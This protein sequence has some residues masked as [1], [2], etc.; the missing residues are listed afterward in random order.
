MLILTLQV[1]NEETNQPIPGV[2]VY[3]NGFIKTTDKHGLVR[4][5]LDDEAKDLV[6][7]QDIFA[8]ASDA[9]ETITDKAIDTVQKVGAAMGGTIFGVGRSVADKLWEGIK[10][11]VEIGK[12]AAKKVGE[13]LKKGFMP[14]LNATGRAA[15]AMGRLVT[16]LPE[17]FKDIAVRAGQRLRHAEERIRQKFR[18][19]IRSLSRTADYVK[20]TVSGI[21]SRSL[22]AFERAG[23]KVLNVTKNIIQR[24]AGAGVRKLERIAKTAPE[25]VKY[26]VRE[27]QR[28]VQSA[29][30]KVINM[31]KR[32]FDS[33]KRIFS[34]SGARTSAEQREIN[35]KAREEKRESKGLIS[36]IIGIKIGS[37][38]RSASSRER[39]RK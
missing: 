16:K 8:R 19:G 6:V 14:I 31:S 9:T 3:Y 37:R 27:G 17:K 7:N 18:I 39:A 15:R 26:L 22:R 4:I 29:A 1:L 5:P 38:E 35:A 36:K 28:K 32:A 33:V 12:E 24:T 2:T 10:P 34:R 11:A 25:T 21:A 23:S 13:V 20:R 30:R